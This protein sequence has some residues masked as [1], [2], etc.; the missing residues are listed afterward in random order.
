MG[1]QCLE[2]GHGAVLGALGS[3]EVGPR[4]LHAI[5]CNGHGIAQTPYLGTLLAD[6]LAGDEVELRGVWRERPQFRR[7]PLMTGPA[8]RAGWAIDRLGDKARSPWISDAKTVRRGAA[9]W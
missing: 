6:R 4:V 3:G 5:G 8:L 7:G 2:L 1:G 9:R